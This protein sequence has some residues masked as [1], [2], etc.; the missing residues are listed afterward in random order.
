[1]PEANLP[2][3]EA[4][5]PNALRGAALEACRERSR[6][7]ARRFIRS[8]VVIDNDAYMGDVPQNAVNPLDVGAVT[9]AFAQQGINCAV[10]RPE[11]GDDVVGTCLQLLKQADAAIIDWHL[12]AGNDASPCKDAIRGLLAEDAARGAPVRL[13]IV[14]TAEEPAILC[15]DLRPYLSGFGLS[16]LPDG[17][18]Y[19]LQNAQRRILV[20]KKPLGGRV[21]NPLEVMPNERH[22]SARPEELPWHVVEAFSDLVDGLVPSLALHAISAIRERSHDLLGAFNKSLD[23]AFLL[24]SML[25]PHMND[26]RSFMARLLADESYQILENDERIRQGISNDVCSGYLNGYCNTFTYRCSE[27]EG[28][29]A[30]EGPCRLCR[31]GDPGCPVCGGGGTE[32]YLCPSCKG[33]KEWNITPEHLLGFFADQGGNN[34]IPDGHILEVMKGSLGDEYDRGNVDFCRLS[35]LASESETNLRKYTNVNV[36]RLQQGTIVFLRGKPCICIIPQCDA[37]RLDGNK[38]L[39]PF[40][41]CKFGSKPDGAS[42]VVMWGGRIKYI[43]IP[44]SISWKKIKAVTFS[45]DDA[46]TAEEVPGGGYCFVSAPVVGEAERF[47]WIGD[48]RP[49][50][51][52]KLVSECMPFLGRVGVDEFEWLRRMKR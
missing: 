39:F 44:R 30:A 8:V 16:P 7:A 12:G 32:R 2:A 51:A 25:I 37:V 33:K 3:E 41:E 14:Y 35:C 10:Y 4:P 48:L 5:D 28:L 40:L 20:L 15:D 26:A 46:V 6:E 11:Q 45:D 49:Q 34:K 29:G 21:D 13:V 23:G 1:M 47:K 17:V 22:Y 18:G 52:T 27:C 9:K 38:R 24:H 36:P 43:S 50:Y 31:G 42:Y 19:G